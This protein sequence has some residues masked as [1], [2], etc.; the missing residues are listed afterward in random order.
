MKSHL[1]GI[2]GV[3]MSALAEF[4]SDRGEEITGSDRFL[5]HHTVVASLFAG[6]RDPALSAGWFGRA[7]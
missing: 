4:L 2:G 3:G 7:G 6:A 1:V 5:D